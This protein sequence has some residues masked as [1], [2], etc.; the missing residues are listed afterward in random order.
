MRTATPYKDLAPQAFDGLMQIWRHTRACGLETSL[1]HLVELRASQLN[2]CAYCMDM[3]ATEALQAGEA[4]RRLA[5]VA[6]WRDAPFFSP[7]ERA[8]LEW[9]E[10]LTELGRHGVDDALYARVREVFTEAETV[11]LTVAITLINAWNRLG[12]AFQLDLPGVD[13]STGGAA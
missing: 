9:T 4:P 10:A 13:V 5:T 1:L 7:R 2:G 8:A 3:H 12:V 6:G 11:H